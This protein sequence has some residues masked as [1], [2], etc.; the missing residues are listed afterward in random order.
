MEDVGVIGW[1]GER[2]VKG[3]GE[4]GFFYF[5][6]LKKTNKNRLDFYLFF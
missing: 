5:S 6:L 2:E 1:V 4:P 3:E